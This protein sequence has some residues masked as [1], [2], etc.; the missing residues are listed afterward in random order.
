MHFCLDIN[1]DINL[2]GWRGRKKERNKIGNICR[3]KRGT[4]THT[5]TQILWLVIEKG[6]KLRKKMIQRVLCSEKENYIKNYNNELKKKESY[7]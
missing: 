5:H 6:T 7:K 2:K 4:H 1:I 3:E